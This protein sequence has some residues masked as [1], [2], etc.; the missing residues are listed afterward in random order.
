MLLCELLPL[1]VGKSVTLGVNTKFVGKF[2]IKSVP[3]EYMA[4]RVL[5][6]SASALDTIVV[7]IK[8]FE[9]CPT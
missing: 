2:D 3:L 4:Y 7:E 9:S 6:F 5:Y 1:F 8:P